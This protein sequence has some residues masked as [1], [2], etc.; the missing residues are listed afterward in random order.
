MGEALTEELEGDEPGGDTDS[1]GTANLQEH[2]SPLAEQEK[3]SGKD[4]KANAATN[5]GMAV[6]KAIAPLDL[7]TIS[8]ALLGIGQTAADIFGALDLPKLTPGIFGAATSS[9]ITLMTAASLARSRPSDFE[10]VEEPPTSYSSRLSSPGDYFADQEAIVESME[11]LNQVIRR[12]T[13]K[14]QLVPLVWRGQQN[15]DWALHSSLFR[16]LAA[17]KGV[18]PPQDNPVGVQPYPSED[19]MVAAERAILRV[20]RESWR[21]SQLTAME[22]IARLQHQGA[23]T[24][25]LDVTRNPYIAAWFAVEASDEHDE[26]DARLFALGTAP[27]PKTPEAE[28][29]NTAYAALSTALTQSFEPFWHALDTTAKRQQLD[30]G[31][32]SNR[33]V[34]VPPEYDPRIA[35]QNA[36]FVLDGVPMFTQ[37]VSRYFKASDG[38]SWTKADLLASASIYAR[39]YSTTRRPPANGA[40]I[41]PSF[42]IRIRSSAKLEIRRML[43]RWFGYSRASIYPDFGG[44]S[45]HIKHAFRDIVAAGP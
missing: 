41:A 34:W 7:P 22:T 42:S 2:E 3:S 9:I 33:L 18:V 24:R 36:A 11:D 23:P 37:R 29:A 12:L 1:D 5:L 17:L 26:S 38:H 28:S 6:L 32:G 15:A 39:M 27:V 25:L 30:W 43:E 8:P 35:A 13:D 10:T 45:Q 44:L 20:A 21:F 14:A 19:D 4:A 16:E 40:S 31:T